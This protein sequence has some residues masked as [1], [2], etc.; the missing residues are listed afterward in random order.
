MLQGPRDKGSRRTPFFLSL[1]KLS[2]GLL[3][4]SDLILFLLALG[5]RHI[6]RPGLGL[7]PFSLL[8]LSSATASVQH[9]QSMLQVLDTKVTGASHA[10]SSNRL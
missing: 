1:T 3:H 4:P 8:S 5:C 2:H 10:R 7:V 6:G 9:T